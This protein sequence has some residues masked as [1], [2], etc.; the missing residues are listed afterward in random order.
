MSKKNHTRPHPCENIVARR[1]NSMSHKTEIIHR[2]IIRRF[3]VKTSIWFIFRIQKD[4]FRLHNE[5]LLDGIEVVL[6]LLINV[7]QLT[8]S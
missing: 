3:V 8:E 1:P 2:K 4:E 6:R 5:A 7:Q